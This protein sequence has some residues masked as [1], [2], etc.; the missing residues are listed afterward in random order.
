MGVWVPQ[1]QN[2]GQFCI[3]EAQGY[4]P[5]PTTA[6]SHQNHVCLQTHI[7]KL[8]FLLFCAQLGHLVLTRRKLG[9]HQPLLEGLSTGFDCCKLLLQV[10]CERFELAS[11]GTISHQL[12]LHEQV[13]KLVFLRVPIL[14]DGPA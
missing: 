1:K 5:T 9:L 4:S 7:Y 6:S 11:F 2:Y 8:S 10:C 3:Y 14:E 13:L 12:K